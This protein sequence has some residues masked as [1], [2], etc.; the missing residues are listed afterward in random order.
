MQRLCSGSPRVHQTHLRW[1]HRLPRPNRSKNGKA[2]LNA[3]SNKQLLVSR[4][5][6]EHLFLAHLHFAGTDD[7]EFY[8]LVR[9]STPPGQ[10]IR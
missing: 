10:P 1:R 6:Y 5:L 3:G 4:Y 9:S 8:R 7:R 2:F